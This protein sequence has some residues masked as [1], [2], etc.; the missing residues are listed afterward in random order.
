MTRAVEDGKWAALVSC[1]APYFQVESCVHVHRSEKARGREPGFRETVSE[2]PGREDRAPLSPS[3]WG[4]EAAGGV[5]RGAGVVLHNDSQRCPLDGGVRQHMSLKGVLENSGGSMEK[6]HF[7]DGKTEDGE[8]GRFPQ[9]ILTTSPVPF[10]LPQTFRDNAM[11][12]GS[13][14]RTVEALFFFSE[15]KQEVPIWADQEEVMSLR[16]SY[17]SF[18]LTCG[19]KFKSTA[20]LVRYSLC[21]RISFRL[22]LYT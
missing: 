15:S 20:W 6:C 7:T 11:S 14:S 2:G 4:T 13:A 3:R 12:L 19:I 1:R 10:C 16:C 21:C 22:H 5:E 9:S 17:V 8:V 18:P